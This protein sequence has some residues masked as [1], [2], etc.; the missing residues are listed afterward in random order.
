MAYHNP[1]HEEDPRHAYYEAQL[2]Q[3]RAQ[4]SGKDD[5]GSVNSSDTADVFAA[6]L[7]DGTKAMRN[8]QY[9]GNGTKKLF[10]VIELDSMLATLA[11]GMWLSLSGGFTRK[12]SPKTYG[13]VHK[14]L[15]KVLGE[16][17]TLNRA[18]ATAALGVNIGI[19]S[20]PKMGTYWES[21]TKR[22]ETKLGILHQIA[23]V[24]DDIKGNHAESTFNRITRSDN[25]MLYAFR[26]RLHKEHSTR[27]MYD[28]ISLAAVIGP[29]LVTAE[30]QNFQALVSGQTLDEVKKTAELKKAEKAAV[31][32]PDSPEEEPLFDFNKM[33]AALTATNL[34]WS[35]IVESV[36]K[37][38]ITHL[39]KTRQPVS[40]LEMV[41]ELEKQVEYAP[42]ARG[43]KMPGSQA[44]ECSLEAYV[45][46]VIV[47]HQ[48]DMADIEPD[49]TVLRESLVK[50]LQPVVKPIADA[51]RKGELSA[52]SLVRLVGEGAIIK[53]KGRALASA[54][55]VQAAMDRQLGKSAS[56]TQVD[57]KE[58]LKNAEY[59]EQQAIDTLKHLSGQER[60]EMG[61]ILPKFILEKAKVSKD[62]MGKMEA[63][64]KAHIAEVV[65]P[66]I[67][68]ATQAANENDDKSSKSQQLNEA[69]AKI[70]RSDD[71]A[72]AKLMTGPGNQHGIDQLAANY[73]IP[74]IIGEKIGLGPLLE[75][76]RKAAAEMVGSASNDDETRATGTHGR[77][78]SAREA[79]RRDMDAM[80][81]D[82]DY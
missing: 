28:L 40:A 1:Y 69:Q 50:D 18:A 60:I 35:Q 49:Y 16:G 71:A 10:G 34:G 76:G 73:A 6:A 30:G 31:K 32:T 38:K 15:G 59:T 62:E 24:L 5:D 12:L 58:F 20:L 7:R 47:Q 11:E 36:S 9:E 75:T 3:M 57:P 77:S 23:P 46:Q 65:K 54:Q 79:Q 68:A 67:A 17:A 45:A 78:F 21:L 13:T 72:L 33:S 64:R 61:A 48:K 37:Q 39:Y 22:H 56:Y 25:E 82:R 52:L 26:R 53:N 2:R 19:H 29:N 81:M 44:R 74:K 8:H 27:S 41:L 14:L 43:F 80:D 66:L 51:I 42:D 4:G 63:Y 70:E 55:E